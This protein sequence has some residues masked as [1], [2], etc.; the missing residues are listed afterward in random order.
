MEGSVLS[1]LASGRWQNLPGQK[2]VLPV[3]SEPWQPW[4][5]IIVGHQSLQSSGLD[6][7]L[8]AGAEL[9]ASGL[10]FWYIKAEL[11]GLN[12]FESFGGTSWDPK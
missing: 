10:D 11:R 4:S 1:T 2:G 6:W 9:M 5:W 3:R 8:L 12:M 7:E